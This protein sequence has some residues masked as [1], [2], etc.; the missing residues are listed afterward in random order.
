MLGVDDFATRRGQ[1]YVTVL[2]DC[3]T[4]QSLDL[5][6]GR[7]AA[8]LAGWL[9][10]HPGPEIICRDRGGSCADSTRTGAPNA[11]QVADR[12]HLW[13]NLATAVERS[14][15]RHNEYLKEVAV[16]DDGLT[17]DAIA[18]H[19]NTEK[20]MSPIEARICERHATVLALPAQ[21]HGIRE[22][23]RE[24]HTGGN[25][26]RRT[27]RAAGPEELL[28]GRRQPRPSQLDPYKPHL[29]KHWAAGFTNAIHLHAEL[30]ELGHRGSHQTISEPPPT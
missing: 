13:Q 21:K 4:G 15:R 24:L 19:A 8:T 28:S 5:L 1:H 20:E 17:N 22:V 16:R 7:N 11:I 12:F 27:A 6:P 2:I 26:V 9:R 3:E 23:A 18:G 14:V 25:T 29:D 30:Q 10:E